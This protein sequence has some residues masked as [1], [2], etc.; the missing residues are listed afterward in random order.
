MNALRYNLDGA[1][2]ICNQI[3]DIFEAPEDGWGERIYVANVVGQTVPPAAPAAP[4]V[5]PAATPRQ[6]PILPTAALQAGM[7]SS[8]M[9]AVT[10]AQQQ[11]QQR[12][13]QGGE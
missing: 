2:R 7:A 1:T 12:R 6:P 9:A 11:Q 10:T 8:S 13:Q 3:G 5:V 4:A